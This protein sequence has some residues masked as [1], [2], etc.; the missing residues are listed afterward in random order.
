MKYFK[1]LRDKKI[2][3]KCDNVLTEPITNNDL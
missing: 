2:S 1:I 3:T